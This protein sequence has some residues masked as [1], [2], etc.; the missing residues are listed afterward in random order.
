MA[1]PRLTP[2]HSGRQGHGKGVGV[3]VW[4][5]FAKNS[6]VGGDRGTAIAVREISQQIPSDCLQ[7]KFPSVPHL[8]S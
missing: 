4:V 6:G 7:P 3:L 1:P 8:L 2:A 5:E